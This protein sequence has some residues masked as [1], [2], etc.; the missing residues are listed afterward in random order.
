MLPAPLLPVHR[1][2]I[3]E[4]KIITSVRSVAYLAFSCSILQLIAASLFRCRMTLAW[5]SDGEAFQYYG[6]MLP[7]NNAMLGIAHSAVS[8]DQKWFLI[9]MEAD[10][11]IRSPFTKTN[12]RGSQ[13]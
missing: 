9:A 7:E 6:I 13:G 12:T 10:C 2:G 4:N 1:R 11:P 8:I 5:A 3:V